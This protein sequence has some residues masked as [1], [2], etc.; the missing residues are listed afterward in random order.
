MMN[1]LSPLFRY[2]G[3]KIGK[4]ETIRQISLA[5]GIPYMTLNRVMKR[6]EKENLIITERIG[7]SVTCSLNIHNPVTKHYLI[8][9]SE[10]SK[11]QSVKKDSVIKN[12]AEIISEKKNFSAVLFGE[13]QLLLIHEKEESSAE[14]EEKLSSQNLVLKS[15][16][17]SE[18]IESL[19]SKD[20]FAVSLLESHTILNN[21]E[22]FWNIIYGVLE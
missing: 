8:I 2:L 10:D 3:L 9:A 22:K 6:L 5:I 15:F 14:I 19:K 13:N 4:R 17:P 12:I 21:P 11:N 16:T 18:L 7:Q 1:N 20:S